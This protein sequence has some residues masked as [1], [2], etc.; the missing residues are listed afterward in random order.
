[1][2]VAEPL[3][4]LAV[5]TYRTLIRKPVLSEIVLNLIKTA[6]IFK[7]QDLRLISASALL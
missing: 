7:Q 3:V 6:V 1:M 4:L 5:V 2:P